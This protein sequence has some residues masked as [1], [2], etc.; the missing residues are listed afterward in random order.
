ML[1]AFAISI[2]ANWFSAI[3][4]VPM[5]FFLV[6]LRHYYLKT[7]REVKR[8]D[9]ILRSPIYNQVSSTVMGRS[10]I[11]AFKL[12]DELNVQF[13][14]LQN[15]QG[16]AFLMFCCTTR[17]L[18]L[19]LDLSVALYI[20]LLSFAFIPLSRSE[21]FSEALGL[22]PGTVGLALSTASNMLG[23]LQWCIRQSSETE[24]HLTSV[25]RILEYAKLSPEKLKVTDTDQDKVKFNRKNAKS[26]LNSI[27]NESDQNP[28][29]QKNSNFKLDEKQNGKVEFDN[30]NFNYYQ[31]GPIILKDLNLKIF[32]SQKIGVVGRT[33]AG[34]SSLISALFRINNGISGKIKISEKDT[35]LEDLKNLRNS[36]SIIPQEPVIFSDTIRANLG[37][38]SVILKM[39]HND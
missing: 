18:S 17:W 37:N 9:S 19:R 26:K 12:E 31:D 35:G 25:E 24:T 3:V 39:I 8:L 13:H 33:G 11:K 5:L 34:K 29:S 23:L 38:G 10:S 6:Y 27:L 1:G 21:E 16:A 22:S 20:T 4:A 32:P 36:I 7:A 14:R 15:D 28:N 30:F 2:W